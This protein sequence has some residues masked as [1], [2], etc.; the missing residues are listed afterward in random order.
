MVVPSAK[1]FIDI[2][3]SKTQRKTP[4]VVHPQFHISR[5]R[6]FYMRKVKYTQTAFH[7]K[8]DQILADFPLLDDIHPFHADLINVL[9]DRDHYKVALGQLNTARRLVDNIAVD[10]VRLIK[11]GDSLFRCKE[12]KRIA[13]GR[14]ATVMKKQS[15]SLD[16][17]EQVRQHLSRL[18]SIDPN[19]MALILC[20]YPNV[21][22]SSFINKI[23]RADV[24]VQPF[25]FITK[26]LFVGHTDH[27]GLR[28]QVIDTP[29][30]LDHPLE[31]RNTIEMQVITALTHLRAV[32]IFIFDISGQCDYSIAQQ[33]NLFNSIRPL[34]ANKPI[35]FALNKIDF[36]PFET[37]APEDKEIISKTAFE[38][39]ATVRTMSTFTEAGLS[40]VKT[41]AC[42]QLLELRVEQ[43][44]KSKRVVDLAS[45]LTIVKPVAR[46]SVDRSPYVPD[47][48]RACSKD[49][50]E[51][52]SLQLQNA[53]RALGVVPPGPPSSNMGT[54]REY[55]PGQDGEV[56]MVPSGKR[57]T[58]LRGMLPHLADVSMPV[59][60]GNW[61]Q[62]PYQEGEDPSKY[63][64]D[65]RKD[66]DL[67]DP[68]QRFDSIPEL[69]NGENVMDYVDPQIDL[70]LAELEAE[71]DARI[72]A[73][74][75]ALDSEEDEQYEL[76]P[77]EKDL[78]RRIR[79]KKILQRKE[80]HANPRRNA[81]LMPRK[82]M[83]R[84]P[85][86]AEQF[87]DHL[88]DLGLDGDE[89]RGRTRDEFVR[90][91]RKREASRAFVRSSSQ[92]LERN[93]DQATEGLADD[94][95]TRS[96]SRSRSKSR[97]VASGKE[98]KSTGLDD[99][100]KKVLAERQRR[101][102]QKKN[103]LLAKSESDRTIQVKKPRHLYSGKRGM[104]KTDR[105]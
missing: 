47:A 74:E 27:K 90:N 19:E 18:P 15:A 45:K 100:G 4:T 80:R 84:G 104:G 50:P 81:S 22:K 82:H 11:Y 31:A 12:L 78:L 89:I 97:P 48:V 95:Q 93:A 101:Q 63:S 30:L 76:T 37:L 28:W 83:T 94:G 49:A 65:W 44:F 23:T 52:D 61:V 85:V 96:R 40:D 70:L 91:T 71:E 92:G 60:V 14:M 79:R 8:L 59:H 5:I 41:T 105:R 102:A 17:L 72:E 20:G 53:L 75:N 33:I 43:R 6:K 73:L 87:A 21:G 51:G 26:P 1:D 77:D 16:Y 25:E 7:E 88:T 39:K 67:E 99:F 68:S 36:R 38:V 66:Y 34:F 55:V 32:I 9:Y 103:N 13:M 58:M 69:Y 10:Y 42:D 35:V 46:D 86:T 64:I 57:H 2:V 62:Q 29:G 24:E 56:G 3:L 98:R 54:V